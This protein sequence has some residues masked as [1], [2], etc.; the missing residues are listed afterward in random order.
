MSNLRNLYTI[1]YEGYTPN[2]NERNANRFV[3]LHSVWGLEEAR[4]FA[5][6]V[7]VIHIHNGVGEKVELV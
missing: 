4:T 1:T 7:S 6:S 2:C 3:R 5:S